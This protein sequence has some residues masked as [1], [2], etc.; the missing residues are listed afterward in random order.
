VAGFSLGLYLIIGFAFGLPLAASTPALMQVHGQVQTLGFLFLFIV[1]VG[2]QLFP[3]FL[4]SPLKRPA[5]VSTGGLLVASGIVL[6]VLG[7]PLPSAEPLRGYALAASALLELLGAALIAS[8][9]VSLVRGSA[10]QPPLGLGALLPATALGSL[11]A[12]F[13]LNLVTSVGLAAG[14]LVVP[15]AQDEALL[16]LELWGFASSVVLAV[17]W[18]VFPKFLLL[19]PTRERLLPAALTMWSLGSFGTP[20]VLALAADASPGRALAALAQLGGAWLFVVALRLYEPPFRASGTPHITNPTRRW[21]R[22]AFALMLCAA[23]ADFG[24]AAA[25]AAGGRTTPLTELSAAR[26]ALAQGFLL[27]LIVLMAA[28]LLPGYSADMNRRPRLLSL[29]VWSLLTSGAA[30]F[31]AELTGGYTPISGPITAA[32]GAVAATAFTVFAVHLWQATG[33]VRTT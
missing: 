22:L 28:R 32:A 17:A 3:R 2:V 16:H 14:G 19:R 5:L 6:R 8:I 27:P 23:A 1:A 15:F 7:Q 12:A 26:H 13:L 11:A 33:R 18:R 9:F 24:L 31:I 21:V 4:G 10:Q 30:R 25:A 20:L 29:L